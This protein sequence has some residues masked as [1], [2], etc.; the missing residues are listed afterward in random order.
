MPC[1]ARAH[2]P[3]PR[4]ESVAHSEA[5]RAGNA[6]EA[7]LR[8]WVRYGAKL[9]N[10]NKPYFRSFKTI[11]AIS[12][13]HRE[14]IEASNS[15]PYPNADVMSNCIRIRFSACPASWKILEPP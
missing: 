3:P 12:A 6:F 7:Q 11:E 2:L 10:E 8:G 15:T 4:I 9:R 1:N 5:N 14:A 13:M